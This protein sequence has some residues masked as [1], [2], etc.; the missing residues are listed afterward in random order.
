MDAKQIVIAALL[1]ALLSGCST[2]KHA[3]HTARSYERW[4][5]ARANVVADLAGQYF[6]TGELDKAQEQ[7]TEALQTDKDNVP[8]MV[9]LGKVFIAKSRYARAID[10]LRVAEAVD[11]N[12]AEVAYLI[13]VAMEKRGKQAEALKHYRKA[14][15][16]DKTNDD[17]V[18]ASA[19][20]LAAM[21]QPARALEIVNA[22]LDTRDSTVAMNGLAGELAM[23]LGLNKRAI[24]YYRDC[25]G[26]ESDNPHA[27]EGLARALFFAGNYGEAADVLKG[28][29]AEKAFNQQS[30][31]HIMLGDCY[32][33][34]NQPRAA[35]ASLTRASELSPKSAKIWNDLAKATLAVGDIPGAMVAANRAKGLGGDGLEAT[36][37]VAYGLMRQGKSLDAARMLDA[38]AQKHPN[39]A[40]VLCVLGRC[41]QKLGRPGQAAS[42]YRRALKVDP[43]NP[44][45]QS[46]VATAQDP[47]NIR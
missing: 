18:L 16:L 3:E 15:S 45:A 20:V 22:R 32:M 6:K 27:R 14:R 28:L 33:S 25:L 1:I 11:R 30:W 39:D 23:M 17:Y 38:A 19:E 43:A 10:Q 47:K 31:V 7:A 36:L 34:L 24:G 44:L 26:L 12:N 29:A 5:E 21:G 8:A 9:L 40:T 37:V 35:Q 46:L 4:A 13:G 2:N 41:Y 42:L